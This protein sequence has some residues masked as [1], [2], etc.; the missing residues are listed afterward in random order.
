MSDSFLQSLYPSQGLICVA[1]QL[2]KGFKHDFLPKDQ[3]IRWAMALD[4]AGRT[5][6]IAQASFKDSSSRKG[7][8][9]AF[10]RSLYLDID[11]GEGKPYPTQ[12]AGLQA[13]GSFCKATN[14]PIPSIVN[15]GNGLYAHWVMD[16]DIP[17]LLWNKLA[18]MFKKVVVHHEAGLDFDGIVADRARVLRPVGATHRKDINN[19]KTVA[20]LRDSGV[21]SAKE[22]IAQIKTA[23]D[24]CG[25]KLSRPK[26]SPEVNAAFIGGLDTQRPSSAEVIASKC[27]Q[28]ANIKACK[29]DVPEP[30]WYAAIGVLRF[31]TEGEDLIQEWSSGHESYTREATTAKISQHEKSG[32]GPTTCTRFAETETGI[33]DGCRYADKTRSPI[34][35]GYAAPQI[36]QRLETVVMAGD[37]STFVEETIPKPPE[38]WILSET[39]VYYNDG[40]E[41]RMVYDQPA[42]VK[43]VNIDHFGESFTIRHRIPFE[44]WK[45]VTFSS[46]ITT[47]LRSFSAAMILAH[48][49]IIGKENK[50]LFMSYIETFMGQ[51]R[52][53]TR[54]S[55][56]SGQM[57]WLVEEDGLAF[58]HGAEIY[59]KDGSAHQVGYSATAPEF[60]RSMRPV[61]GK[62]HWVENTKILNQKGMEGLAFEFLCT[63]FG[64]PLVRFTGYEGVM[65]SV[66]GGSGM[67]KTLV[68]RWGLSAWGNSR[69][70]MLDPDDTKNALASR[71][72]VYNTL[73]AYIDEISNITPEA[74]SDLAYKVTRGRDK[75]RLTKNSVERNNVNNWNMLA[76][77][78]SN[79][80]LV[81]KLG[82]M[83][84]DPDAEIN[85]IFEYE[86]TSGLTSEEGKTI[87]SAIDQNYGVVG[88][89]YALWL[90]EHQDDHATELR[91]IADI[92]EK[93]ADTRPEERFWVMSAAV[94]IYGGK[95]AYQL[96]LSHV[97]VVALVPWICETIR[98]MRSYKK[99]QGFDAVSF[100]GSLLDK[101]VSAVLVV[102]KYD[103]SSKF[104]SGVYRE[105][106]G[107]LI[108]RIEEDINRLWISHAVIKLELQKIHVS[109]RKLGAML[110][111]QGL[112][113]MGKRVSL[114]KGTVYQSLS[115][116]CW[117][118]DLNHPNL[119]QRTLELV[120]KLKVTEVAHG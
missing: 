88:K 36:L 8:N 98:A 51:L 119:G 70:L 60:V 118:F 91:K 6:F 77:V 22:L 53:Q 30:L 75:L 62:D 12:K 92:I 26:A 79:H 43:C 39:G 89:E 37:T 67:G 84:G 28:I 50:G 38:N 16:M 54:M 52:K 14:I 19:P 33:C 29:G 4:K 72:G 113:N 96:G 109:S 69:Q 34:T 71:F 97:N 41:P 25:G 87:F 76:T 78:S 64:S 66:V 93:K 115:T 108:A 21:F 46:A 101:Y 100:L 7:D 82:A 102:P 90:T 49:G 114:G 95:I 1:T 32:V 45:D 9:T 58:V 3:A 116:N 23:F 11:C 56:L 24:A 55:K 59:R 15:S 110:H 117:E 104:G 17:M 86:L 57:G 35:L 48:I 5:V 80:S 107:H 44:G 94:A 65:L 63:A 74:L 27:A 112:V 120:D 99:A 81:D 105:P 2:E 40:G 42:Y 68:G 18:E 85:R 73:P 31:T 13:L 10:H 103:D 83:K 20:L 111:D 61:G 106:R 47:E